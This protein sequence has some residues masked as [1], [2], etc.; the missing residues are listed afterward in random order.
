MEFTPRISVQQG[1]DLLAERLNKIISAKMAPQLNG[2]PWTVI[3]QELDRAKGH[4]GREYFATDLQAQLRMLTE[5]L[6]NM[7]YPFDTPARIVSTLGSELR[8]VRNR[9][10]H[11]DAFDVM[12]AW[13]TQDFI[14][15]LLEY[16]QDADG[17]AAAHKLQT[18]ALD[19][20]IAQRGNVPQPRPVE[21]APA[22][23]EET[24][25]DTVPEELVV[26]DAEMFVREDTEQTPTIGAERQEFEPWTTVT[27]GEPEMLDNMRK[28]ANKEL[29]R[30]TA[31]EVAEFEGPVHMDRLTRLVAGSFGVLRLHNSRQTKL[32]RQIR[33]SGLLI[34]EYRFAWPS[35]ILREDWREFRPN[36]ST[37]LRD[38]TQ[39]S[40]HEVANAAAFILKSHPDLTRDE[41]EFQTL[42]TFGRKRRTQ[43]IRAHLDTAL[44]L[45]R[46]R[47]GLVA[48]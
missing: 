45:L 5:R 24:P 29:V 25:Q 32:S 31:V 21:P 22:V 46:A 19:G 28:V 35:T 15:R 41:L 44:N 10:A 2:L 33:Q 42:K 12:D 26:P 36:D 8:I 1:L 14:V 16:F 37:V 27:V 3:L 34:D 39:I 18:E 43:D 48:V 17:I 47:S 9:W 13:R 40:P 20:V 7:G 38:F 4:V 30:A 23:Q 11:Q 6:G